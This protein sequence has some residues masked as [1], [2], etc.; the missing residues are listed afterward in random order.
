MVTLV[1]LDSSV[2]IAALREE[3]AAHSACIRLLEDVKDGKYLAIEPY[4]VLVEIVAAVKRRTGSS[5]LA[6]NIKQYLELLDG[7]FFLELTKSRADECAKICEKLAVRGMD[8]IVIQTALENDAV[9]ITLD[10]E[11]ENQAKKLIKTC[12][13]GEF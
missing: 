3:E 12:A 13:P 10:K 6:A 5:E 8:S 11:M 9:L 1:T 4:T 7:I 2:F